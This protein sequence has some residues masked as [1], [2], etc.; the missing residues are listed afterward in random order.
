MQIKEKKKSEKEKETKEKDVAW[1]GF[2]NK[3]WI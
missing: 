2:E 1:I 3:M